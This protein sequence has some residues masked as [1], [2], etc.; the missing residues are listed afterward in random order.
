[1]IP[2]WLIPFLIVPGVVLAEACLTDPVAVSPNLVTSTF[3]KSRNLPQYN[4]SPHVHWGV[5]FQA[6]NTSDRSIGADLLA[7][8]NGTVVGAGF[9]GSGY[10]N[11]VAIKRDNGDIVIYSHMA[12]IEPE[13][14]SGGAIG[15]KDTE[16]TPKIG[17]VRVGAGQKIGVAGGTAN[18]MTTNERAI[19]LHLE[20]VTN[21]AGNKLRE[22]NDGTDSTRSRF[23]RNALDY[24][25]KVPSLAPGAGD[26]NLSGSTSAMEEPQS[27][28]ARTVQKDVVERE[29]Y[30]MPDMPPYDSYAGMSESQIIEAEMLRR[31]LDTEWEDNLTKW[32]KRGLWVE[33]SRI[34]G[35]SLWLDQK[36]SDKKSRIEAMLAMLLAG[37]TNQHFSAQLGSLRASAERMSTVNKL[38]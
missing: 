23:M 5:D 32:S 1:M 3:G 28:L 20:Y 38:N 16:G 19:H 2:R 27:G 21:Y 22:T 29:R 8:T 24:M 26:P 9:W 17:N 18:H 13:L 15:F 37:K 36:L 31:T 35:I 33:L 25:C 4:G 12:K 11:R 7:S 6:R 14:K 34:D 10:G 30:G